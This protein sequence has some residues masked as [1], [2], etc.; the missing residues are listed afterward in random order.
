MGTVATDRNR[1][2]PL[3]PRLGTARSWIGG[4][5]PISRC[6]SV[7]VILQSCW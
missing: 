2:S 3:S 7:L 5:T 6:E 4:V 1:K